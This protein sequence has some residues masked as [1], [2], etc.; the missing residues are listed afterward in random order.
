MQANSSD[1]LT[2]EDIDASLAIVQHVFRQFRA[3][4][5]AEAGHVKFTTKEEDG[6]PVTATDM[7][8]ELAL[9]AALLRRFPGVPV[10][11]EETG[12]SGV[13]PHTFWLVDPID[14][15]KSFIENVPTFTSMAVL[16]Q[17]GEATASVIY[18]P[19]TDGMFVAQKSKGAYKNGV[20][21]DLSKMP[22]PHVAF[23]K[24]RFISA[25]NAILQPKN[26]V[27]EARASGSG[28]GFSTMAD[29]LAAARF[30]LPG[31]GHPHDYAPGALLVREAGGAIIP[32]KEDGY[33][34]ETRSFVACHPDLESILRAH[35]QEIRKLE[36]DLADKE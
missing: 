15:T 29:G 36:T 35:V 7:E 10:L 23:A 28:Y 1:R 19:S 4:I 24:M 6:T 20:R 34:Y 2:A 8:I 13:L 9:Q 32:I 27:C 5:L 12:Y 25:L 16:I 21:L 30:N 26:V 33:T 17:D 22:L 14:G 11:G 31:G 3:R 18:D